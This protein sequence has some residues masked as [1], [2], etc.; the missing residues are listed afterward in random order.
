MGGASVCFCMC[1]CGCVL[2]WTI[3]ISMNKRLISLLITIKI[4]NYKTE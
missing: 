2:V 3:Y 1:A 4:E